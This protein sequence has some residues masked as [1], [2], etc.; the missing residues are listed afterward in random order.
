MNPFSSFHDVFRA[1]VR[2]F[3]Q[4]RLAPHADDW[5]SRQILPREVFE[6]LGSAGLLGLNQSVE[7]GG[8]ELDFFYTVVLAEELPRSKMLGLTLSIMAQTNIFSPLL[9]KLGSKEQKQEFLAPAIAGRKIG[10]LASTEPTGGSDIVRATQCKAI[11]DGDCWRVT[12]EKKYI[13]NAPIADFVVALVRTKPEPEPTSL[14]LLLIP[15]D[16]PGFKMREPLSKLGMHTSPTGWFELQ[17]CRVPKHYTLGKPNLG[18]FYVT[19]NLLQER[20][21]AGV[22]ALSF[23]TLILNDTMKYLTSRKA[24]N[25]TLVDLQTVRHLLVEM[26]TELEICRRFVYSLCESYKN[27]HMEAKQVCMSKFRVADS[28][29][30]ITERCLQLH[31]GSGFLTENWLTRAYRDV[32]LLSLAGGASELMKDLIAGYMRL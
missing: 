26:A 24:Y 27:G 9:A 3:V 23:A 5:E 14:S 13:T 12:G 7:Y 22:S 21:I 31:G 8:R 15:T 16:A 29:Q 25:A 18:F 20:L 1:Q 10:A 6:E 2:E 30:W 19:N 28:V 4:N 17:E 32:R 11:D